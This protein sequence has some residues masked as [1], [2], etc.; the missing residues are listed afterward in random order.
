MEAPKITRISLLNLPFIS[1]N[2]FE[3]M[4]NISKF[5]KTKHRIIVQ[6]E[7][8]VYEFEGNSKFVK[9]PIKTNNN[10]LFAGLQPSHDIRIK[11]F[12]YNFIDDKIVESKL[13][14]FGYNPLIATFF[15]NDHLLST[16][17]IIMGGWK[18]DKKVIKVEGPFDAEGKIVTVVKQGE[19]HTFKATPNQ[20]MLS[21]E[22]LTIKWA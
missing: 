17:P 3:V 8:K 13:Q 7:N 20:S 18:K 6:I 21:M 16:V 9:I 11:G 15:P 2:T 4:I 19:S 14:E 1:K 10:P 22:L 12:I 5:D